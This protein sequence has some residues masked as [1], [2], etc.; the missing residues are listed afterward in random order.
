MGNVAGRADNGS[1]MS[2]VIG[3]A[4]DAIDARNFSKTLKKCCG[5]PDT[6]ALSWP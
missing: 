1:P 6:R 5:C 2:S 3:M 4:T